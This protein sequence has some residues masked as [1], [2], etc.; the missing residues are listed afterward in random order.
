VR[1]V[2]HQS[3]PHFL[4]LHG[5]RLKGFAVEMV[6]AR[7]SGLASADVDDHLAKLASDGHVQHRD[8][9]ITGWSLT[10]SGRA[11]HAEHAAA[12]MAAADCRDVVAAAYQ[13][14]LVVNQPFLAVC[15]DWQLRPGPDGEQ[16][17]NDHTDAAHD[18][19]VIGRL[20]NVNV[21]V[22]PICA[23]LSR[24]MH[25]FRGYGPRMAEALAKVEGGE[26]DWFTGALIESYHT[27]WFELHEDL[28][29][30]LAIERVKEGS[31]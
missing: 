18:A 10:P 2:S 23:D 31:S 22:Q 5:L 16:I 9:R 11:R 15:T 30:T 4:V 17:I 8:G 3:D 20:R 24:A 12:D 27:L 1:G 14:F 6:V 26:R 7:F 28:L 21:V 13:Q 29:A 19:E 25:R